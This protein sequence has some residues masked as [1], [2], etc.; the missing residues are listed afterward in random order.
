MGSKRMYRCTP[1]A[2]EGG[3]GVFPKEA[4]T[5]DAERD[6]YICPQ[7]EILPR[8]R[9][10]DQ[11]QTHIYYGFYRVCRVCPLKPQ[12]TTNRWRHISRSYF[13]D[14]LDRVTEYHQT[15]AYQK[16]MRKRQVWVEPKFAESKLWHQGRR[17]R[18]RRIEKV[19][20]EALLRAS[21]QNLKQLLRRRNRPKPLKPANVHALAVP[22]P[23]ISLVF[24]LFSVIWSLFYDPQYDR[25]KAML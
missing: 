20:I 23:L 1:R 14:Y 3:K 4:F 19:N 8:K 22:V 24:R 21:V 18:L 11:T 7:G 5:Y 6:C 10:D 17:F 15:E 12:C 9:S 25:Q 16:A 2:S 13:Q